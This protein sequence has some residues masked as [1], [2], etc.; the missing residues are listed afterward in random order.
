MYKVLLIDDENPVHLAIRQLVDWSAIHAYEPY[1]AYNG[2]EG[3]E[4]ME[5]LQPDIAFVDMNMPLLDGKG[6]LAVAS[7]N[8]PY[9]QYIV[10]S[11][12][13][14]FQYAQAA[15]RHNVVDY[16]LKPIDHEELERAIRKAL[17]R[18][19]DREMAHAERTPVEAIAAIRDY[20]DRNYQRD[21]RVAELA[22]RFYFSKEYISKLF[23]QQYGCPIYDYVLKARMEKA[24]EY[25]NNPRAQIQ[26][27]AEM[28]GYSNANYFGKA[29]KHRYGITPSEYREGQRMGR[30]EQTDPDK[31]NQSEPETPQG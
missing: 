20:I 7:R 23:R 17:A 11:G 22:E 18:L 6:F 27:I 8:H 31:G 25:L 1:S 3:L 26:D 28:L 9:C 14:D 13:D 21:I 5:R 15:I 2:K 16:L 19:P 12:Y 10:I 24:C 29:F 4:C 30:T